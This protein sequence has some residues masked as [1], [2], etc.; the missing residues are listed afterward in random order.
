L[1]HVPIAGKPEKSLPGSSP[2]AERT[3]SLSL[4]LTSR[5]A[6]CDSLDELYFLLT[7]DLR[8]LAVYDRC[9]LITHMEGRSRFVAA[10]HLPVVDKKSKL[11]LKLQELA[12]DLA[13]LESPLILT[14]QPAFQ[15]LT[16]ETPPQTTLTALQEYGD[17][18]GWNHLCCIPLNY[19]GKPLGHLLMEFSGDNLPDKSAVTTVAKAAPI[20][21]AAL[22]GRWLAERK[23]A[24]AR[25]V[26]SHAPSGTARQKWAVRR[27]PFIAVAATILL[28]LLFLVPFTFSVGGEAAI[29]PKERQ[30]AFCKISGLIDAVYVK[31]GSSVEKDRK[32]A[33]LDPRELDFRIRREERQFEL[34]TQ[35]MALSRSRAIDDPSILARAKLTELKRESVAAEL[36]FLRWQR[37]FL[38]ITAP[39]AGVIVTKDVETLVGKKLDAGEAFC[40]IA[41]PGLLCAD[42]LVPEDRIM[43]VKTGQ[44]ARVYLNNAPRKGYR[45]KVDEIAP[46]SEVEP[47]L[48]NVY[49]VVATFVDDPGAI[50][51]GMKGTGSIDTGATNLWTILS[52]RLSTRLNHMLLY[53]R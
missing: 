49:K 46:R 9:L 26:G 1:D 7:N 22:A 32:L 41:E 50:K 42:I 13:K 40:E 20:F 23:P 14:R 3:L 6:C 18:A 37:Q 45:L 10:T 19:N 21:G 16:P 24:V 47:R 44:A 30:Y 53:F 33:T 43:R 2:D 27:A 51:V 28:I 11:A 4:E 48:G 29:S 25:I 17:L 34:L 39:V 35:E 8:T 38:V 12:P 36:E 5:A 15:A 52:L 31:Q